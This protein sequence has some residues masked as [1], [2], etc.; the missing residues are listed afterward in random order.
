MIWRAPT[1]L[2]DERAECRNGKGE[3]GRIELSLL[4]R[5]HHPSQEALPTVTLLL[6]RRNDGFPLRAQ[7][8][9]RKVCPLCLLDISAC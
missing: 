5:R 1:H 3:N 2:D 6:L 8:R 7:R 9:A 4:E